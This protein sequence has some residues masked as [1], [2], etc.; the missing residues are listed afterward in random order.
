ME[1]QAD[2]YTI[3]GLSPDC[4]AEEIRRAYLDQVRRIHPDVSPRSDAGEEFLLLQA[5]YE[6]LSDPGRRAAYDTQAAQALAM[7]PV[8][9][10]VVTSRVRL[11][12]LEEPQVIYTLLELVPASPR[13]PAL[14]PPL[15]LCLVLDR[16]TSMQG[17]RMDTLKSAALELTRYLKTE[18]SLGVVSFSDRAEVVVPAH[19][20]FDRRALEEGIRS[21]RPGGGTEIFHGLQ[22]GLAEVQRA[23]TSQSLNHLF[24]ITDGRTYGD[25]T[26]CLEL[27]D[28]AERAG[29]RISALGIGNEWNSAFLDNLAA[30]SGGSCHFVQQLQDLKQFFL[31]KL[32]QLDALYAEGVRLQLA[33]GK[34]SRI[35][36]A[37]RLRPDPAPLPAG[38]PI[39]CGS[40]PVSGGLAVLLEFEIG[41]LDEHTAR[42]SLASGEFNL[43]LTSIGNLATGNGNL[44]VPVNLTLGVYGQTQPLMP[45][46]PL[47][48]AVRRVT[49]YRLQEQAQQDAVGG[50][51]D[52]ASRRLQRLATHL[53]ADGQRS[54]ARTA[55]LEAELLQQ[56]QQ[57]SAEGEKRMRYGTRALLL[58]A[59]IPGSPSTRG[60]SRDIER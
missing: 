11:P 8:Q 34:H 59:S 25:E 30:R 55:L 33:P 58:P 27:A 41:P 54:L 35:N 46:A 1:P 29:I 6:T 2:F 53:L 10:K 7:Q 14:P 9:L 15:N 52:Q 49:M 47:I 56:H 42:C 45:P 22:V 5:A 37:F 17:E 31:D 36:F 16:S 4:T 13:T 44:H 26:P 32:R 39:L 12:W 20:P 48:E 3:L 43:P 51:I 60:S 50:R 24:L 23:A 57:I 28:Q 19:S 38:P 18:D 21:I 40:L